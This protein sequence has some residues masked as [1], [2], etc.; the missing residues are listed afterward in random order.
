[1]GRITIYRPTD[2]HFTTDI[3]DVELATHSSVAHGQSLVNVWSATVTQSWSPLCSKNACLPF[4][5]C[6]QEREREVER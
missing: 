3:L 5:I 2:R 1:M 4:V 6:G